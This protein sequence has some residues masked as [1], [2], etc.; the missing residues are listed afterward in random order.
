MD[1][2]PTTNPDRRHITLASTAVRLAAGIQQ[3][4]HHCCGGNVAH[5]CLPACLGALHPSGR[6]QLCS[7][8]PQVSRQGVVGVGAAG[9]GQVPVMPATGQVVQR[10]H[11]HHARQQPLQQA[12]VALAA[13]LAGRAPGRGLRSPGGCSGGCSCWLQVKLHR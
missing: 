6:R 12:T 8:I 1:P 4:T 2:F 10:H 11:Q 5:Q 7:A 9:A 3:L 13:L